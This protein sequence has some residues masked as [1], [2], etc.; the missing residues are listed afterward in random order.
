MSILV[1]ELLSSNYLKH[2]N[3]ISLKEPGK[4]LT[5]EELENES[6]RFANFLYKQGLRKGD[7]ALIIMNPSIN[8]VIAIVGMMKVGVIF[9]PLN[10]K[11]TF[12]SIDIIVEETE[13]SLYIIDHYL[14]DLH[15]YL[16]LKGKIIVNG[17]QSFQQYSNYDSVYDNKNVIGKDIVNIIYTSGSTG[18]PKGVMI[19]HENITPFMTYVVKQF[20]HNPTTKTLSK[21]PISF[22]PFLTEIVPSFIGGGTVYLYN[23]GPSIRMFLKVLEE[24]RITNFGCGPSLLNLL[25]ENVELVQK[26]NLSS[27]QEIYF[28]YENCPINTIKELQR[29]LP[30]V[31][32]INGY[33]TTET[34]ACSTF[35]IVEK[36]SEK[37]IDKLPLGTPIKD[38]ELLILTEELQEAAI[39]EIGEMV[40]RGNT[41]MK[42]YWKDE[43]LTSKVLRPHPMHPFSTEKV[44]FTGDLVVKR[45]DGHI[46]FIGRKDDQ[47]KINGY[48]IELIG[49]KIKIESIPNVKEACVIAVDTNVGK[50]LICYVTVHQHHP[51]TLSEIKQK[52]ID[53]LE[54]YKYP[55]EWFIID[56]FPRN[57]NSKIDRRKLQEIYQIEQNHL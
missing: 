7:R 6:N 30:N 55:H 54:I 1:H 44:Y 35:Y 32:F 52:S 57:F 24:E 11:S 50:K 39:N 45:D 51:K 37:N 4:T 48:R 14:K 41:L 17:E 34:Y 12:D 13:P 20:N 43:D 19:S 16:I 47:V 27:L 10:T 22:D 49:L 9:V 53:V 5:H 25:A 33:G 40:I 31:S 2:R 26:Y 29:H 3:N 28:G 56:E 38:T 21:S 46:Y 36:I 18:K 42:G 23:A 8:A 15:S